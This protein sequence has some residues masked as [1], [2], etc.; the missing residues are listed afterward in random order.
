MTDKKL[1][2]DELMR[3]ATG[4]EIAAAAPPTGR[5]IPKKLRAAVYGRDGY[6]CFRRTLPPCPRRML[7][8][9]PSRSAPHRPA[10]TPR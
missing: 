10:H 9:V 7:F 3:E 6:P 4:E 8:P 2:Y 5:Y 1:T